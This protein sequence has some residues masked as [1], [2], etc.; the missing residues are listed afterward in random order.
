[1][2]ASKTKCYEELERLCRSI[3]N[4]KQDATDLEWHRRMLR[5]PL[6]TL[7]KIKDADA[8]RRE[9]AKAKKAHDALMAPYGYY[10]GGAK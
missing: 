8:E 10:K 5:G 2:G 7:A 9:R 1:M 6:D 3:V 4:N